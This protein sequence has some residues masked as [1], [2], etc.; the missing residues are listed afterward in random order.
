MKR[1]VL[2]VLIALMS[3]TSFAQMIAKGDAAKKKVMLV[4]KQE[5]AQ[6]KSAVVDFSNPSDAKI[7]CR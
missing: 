7:A 6:P 5:L 2:A 3:L 4:K 1:I